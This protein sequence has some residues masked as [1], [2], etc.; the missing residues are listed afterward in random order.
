[1]SEVFKYLTP[2]TY[3]LLIAIWGG[4]VAFYFLHRKQYRELST[5]LAVLFLV[6]AIDA[7]RTLFESAFF[8][9]WY[10]SRVGLIRKS[11]FD[12]LVQPEIV[13]VPKAINLVVA[14]VIAG[15]LLRRLIPS[16]IEE[17]EQQAELIGRLTE[18]Q[19]R[20]STLMS[21]LPGM[22]YR[23]LN[24]PQRTM[25][26]VSEGS[27][28]LTGYSPS[29][30]TTN[31]E[32]AF[33]DLIHA[34]DRELVWND[35]QAATAR[36]KPFELT[37]RIRTV[38]GKEKWVW[39]QGCGVFSDDGDLLALEGFITDVTALKQAEE[40]LQDHRHKLERE[41][42][43]RTADLAARTKELERSHA[44]LQE[45][46]YAASHDL[47]EPLRSVVTHTQALQKRYEAELDAAANRSIGFAVDAA[48][49]MRS[50]VSDIQDYLRLVEKMASF[51]EV[52][53]EA[54]VT[55]VVEELRS[56]IIE[57]NAAVHLGTLPSV[58]ADGEHLSR[59][60]H[61]LITNALRFHVPD[62]HPDVTISAEAR[63]GEW[64]FSVTDNG[65]G[66]EAQYLERIFGVFKRLHTQEAY[67]GT[68]MGLAICK[69][70]IERH[71]GRIWVESEPGKG[72]TFFFTLPAA[73]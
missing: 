18:S 64:V 60:F 13:F 30:L 20:L 63:D 66:I 68:G 47:Q 33:A 59:V 29:A 10:T 70:I 19:R 1:M 9:A 73:E 3:W 53:T 65:I 40:K 69:K 39:E 51:A 11:V 24:D 16:V 42:A 43:R 27:L 22:A 56:E 34:D 14:V 26:F 67:P 21:N 2:I 8:G 6:L 55:N 12:F 58:S 17:R 4:I 50:R 7:V 49:M 25:E 62:H 46:A 72:S 38:S 61:H 15:L 41:V 45:F 48:K 44:E 71:G 52:D 31:A 54:L 32:I 5:P 23:C 57:K 35:V 37:Y 36:K 28:L